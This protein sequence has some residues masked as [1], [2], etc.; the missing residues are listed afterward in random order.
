MASPRPTTP[1]CCSA[2]RRTRSRL[3]NACPVSEAVGRSPIW[4]RRPCGASAHVSNASRQRAVGLHGGFSAGS[5]KHTTTLEWLQ[6]APR[7]HVLRRGNRSKQRHKR[8]P[9][10]NRSE[11][12]TSELQSRGHLVCRLLLE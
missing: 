9:A 12:H 10:T 1:S 6:S 4:R 5:L 2:P 7:Y 3:R 11:E 8:A